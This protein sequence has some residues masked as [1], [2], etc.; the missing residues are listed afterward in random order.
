MR[1]AG[2]ALAILAAGIGAAT[3]PAAAGAWHETAVSRGG[4]DD[5]RNGSLIVPDQEEPFAAVLFIAGSGPTDRDGNQPGMRTDAY[6]LLAA[7]LA[8]HG[9]GSLR[10]D[11]R[12]VAASYHPGQRE[13]DLRFETFVDDAQDWLHFLRTQPFVDRLYIV[14]HS[15]GALIGTLVAERETVAGF[16]SLA[17][18][19]DRASNILRRQLAAGPG[20]TITL[21]LAEPTL[22]KLEAGKLDP[23]PNALLGPLFRPSVQPYLISWFRYD[24]AE[25]IAKVQ[26]PVLILQGTT[27]FQISVDDAKRLKAARPDATLTLIEGMNHILRIAPADRSANIKTYSQPELPLAT[28]LVEAIIGF[29]SGPPR[30]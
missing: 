29:I 24:P 9:I 30:P 16:I 18:A 10:F 17:G 26:A 3:L 1:V 23:A 19:G 20:G 14:G 6:K 28:G 22:Q 25:E 8:D 5:Q 2:I 4:A 21:Q 15:E 7:A 12:M 27:D 11:K 13:E